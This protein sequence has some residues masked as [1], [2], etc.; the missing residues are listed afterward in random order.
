MGNKWLVGIFGLQLFQHLNSLAFWNG[1][2]TL[3][4]QVHNTG[5]TNIVYRSANGVPMEVDFVQTKQ[6]TY[7][8]RYLGECAG[9]RIQFDSE[10]M[11]DRPEAELNCF[12]VLCLW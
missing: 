3:G 6:K 8:R 9:V 2:M 7:Q 4:G 11:D 5:S 12:A 10:T 1:C